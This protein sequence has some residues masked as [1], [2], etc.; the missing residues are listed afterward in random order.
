M[1]KTKPE[2]VHYF[3]IRVVTDKPSTAKFVKK[4]VEGTIKKIGMV[5]SEE[6]S[7]IISITSVNYHTK[8]KDRKEV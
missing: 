4:V 8:K 6:Y 7:G 3:T 1:K 5:S 2:K